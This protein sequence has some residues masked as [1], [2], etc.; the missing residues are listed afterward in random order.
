MSP[1]EMKPSIQ[2]KEKPVGERKGAAQTEMCPFNH[3]RAPSDDGRCLE[4]R[5]EVKTFKQDNRSA[6][7]L[8]NRC[9]F[10][11]FGSDVCGDYCAST[12]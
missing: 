6:R 8:M 12:V 4:L 9:C 10:Q 5:T 2:T 11:T 1:D 7:N 3:A